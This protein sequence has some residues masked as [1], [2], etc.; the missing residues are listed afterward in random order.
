[1]P[2]VILELA[3]KLK[4]APDRAHA[5]I[6]AKELVQKYFEEKS[7]LEAST[8]FYIHWQKLSG[9][10]VDAYEDI[11]EENK[12]DVIQKL[13]LIL[14]NLRSESADHFENTPGSLAFKAIAFN[15]FFS[16]GI[17]A[18]LLRKPVA[19]LAVLYVSVYDNL[20]PCFKII[21]ALIDMPTVSKKEFKTAIEHQ[22]SRGPLNEV[23]E[24]FVKTKFAD[25]MKTAFANATTP[26]QKNQFFSF[27]FA[28]IH[29]QFSG[30]FTREFVYQLNRVFL[31]DFFMQIDGTRKAL[32][33]FLEEHPQHIADF[34][35]ILNSMNIDVMLKISILLKLFKTTT[36]F[37][38]R[39]D[40]FIH[41]LANLKDAFKA[42]EHSTDFKDLKIFI[43]QLIQEIGKSDF[44][45]GF[46]KLDGQDAE[47]FL[48]N[49]RCDP[50]W[51]L[52]ICPEIL[53]LDCFAETRNRL[54]TD[55]YFKNEL[56]ELLNLQHTKITINILILFFAFDPENDIEKSHY[57]DVNALLEVIVLKYVPRNCKA[58]WNETGKLNIPDAVRDEFALNIKTWQELNKHIAGFPAGD[59]SKGIKSGA[60]LSPHDYIFHNISQTAIAKSWH[61]LASMISDSK[62][63][64]PLHKPY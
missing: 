20:M 32:I 38:V 14:L 3:K 41:L 24:A 54:K 59:L 50:A 52:A 16:N 25:E 39:V 30:E 15:L 55:D 6:L 56:L 21:F 42:T 47:R 26:E 23:S 13:T 18:N 34:F 11:T 60:R 19:D 28:I 64:K 63:L 4:D 12:D 40:I 46:E 48:F 45:K 53:D 58:F 61:Q 33:S 8:L 5:D 27:L 10:L 51:I 36:D 17:A 35:K 37:S 62:E 1:M 31:P 49:Y 57:T 9:L 43:K 2:E 7:D 29:D 22:I 44:L